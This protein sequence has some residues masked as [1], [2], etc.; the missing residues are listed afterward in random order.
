M[1]VNWTLTGMTCAGCAHSAASIAEGT[2]GLENVVVRYASHS[3]KATVDQELLDLPAFKANLAKAGYQLESEKVGMEVQFDRQRKALRRQALE[4]LLAVLFAG[5]LLYLGMSHSM[6]SLMIACQ[7]LLAVVLSGYFGRKIHAKAFALAK[8]G[9]TNM[10]TLVSLGSI[11]A[12]GYSLFNLLSGNHEIYFESAG[13]IIA[14]VLIG[15]YFEQ[16]GKLQNS[17]AVE[18]LLALQPKMATKVVDGLTVQV[19]VGA[20]EIDEVV[21]VKPGEQI[22]V[23]GIVVE[24]TSSIDESTFTGE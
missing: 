23:D 4:L 1:E 14:F 13:L 24:G 21:Q 5:P 15:K 8:M 22:P 19:D 7:G 11:V 10:D 12:F 16:R 9:A 6:E 2:P 17:K 20:L 3:F 18:S